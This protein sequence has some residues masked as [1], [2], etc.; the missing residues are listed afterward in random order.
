MKCLIKHRFAIKKLPYTDG[1]STYMNDIFRYMDAV[2]FYMDSIFA[3]MA[4]IAFY[5]NSVSF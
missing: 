2:S 5:M 1:V 3:D 4:G